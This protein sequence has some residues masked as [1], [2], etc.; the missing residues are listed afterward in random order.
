MFRKLLLWVL[1]LIAALITLSGSTVAIGAP[2]Q[3][4]VEQTL[5]IKGREVDGVMIMQDGVAQSITCPSPQPY[6]T[7]DGTSTGWACF[8]PATEMWLMNAK[9]QSAT[10]YAQQPVYQE[11]S[12]VYS[13]YSSPYW[14]PYPI[15]YPYPNY[16]FYYGGPFYWGAPSFRF[17][18][19]RPW[20]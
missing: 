3:E 7:A 8:D 19:G 14:Y 13:Y 5:L 1:L 17:G 6:V 2:R 15:P 11:R 16:P 12:T 20:P 18:F 4:H 9:A 10:G